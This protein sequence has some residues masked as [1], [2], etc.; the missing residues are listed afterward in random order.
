MSSDFWDKNLS[1]NFHNPFLDKY[2]E[3][4]KITKNNVWFKNK[5][6][7][8]R[9]RHKM[10]PIYEELKV[11]DDIRKKKKE[12]KKSLRD[13]IKKL[14]SSKL[15]KNKINIRIKT[16]KTKNEK[17]MKKI[18]TVTKACR[19]TIGFNKEQKLMILKWIKE[20][21]KIYNFCVDKYHSDEDYFTGGFTNAKIKIFVELYGKNPKPCPYDV[22]TDEVRIFCSNLKSCTTN[23]K[24]GNIKNYKLGYKRKSEVRSILIPKKAISKTGIFTTKMGK[25]SNFKINTDNIN[26]DSRL[27]YNFYNRRFTLMVPRFIK[28]TRPKKPG[29]VVSLDPGEKVFMSFFSNK[30]YGYIGKDVRKPILEIQKRIKQAQRVLNKNRNRKGKR[31]RKKYLVKRKIKKYYKKIKH[32]V[33]EMHNLTADFLCKRYERILIPEFKTQNILSENKF[34]KERKKAYESGNHDKVKK[35]QRT[36]RLSKRVKFV[37]NMLSHYRFRQHLQEKGKEYGCLVETVTE[38]FTSKTCTNCGKCS[39]KYKNRRKNC[40]DCGCKMDRD[41]N[42]ARNI[43]IKNFHKIGEVKVARPKNQ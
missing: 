19:Y 10:K 28:M 35:L 9:H 20:C 30:D 24:N 11:G 1:E 15:D 13:T 7:R 22:L 8:L 36:R 27:I 12:Y 6:F 43:L 23:K 14:K 2:K 41:V 33:K 3:S 31:I 38:E 4:K 34:K 16:L 17:N 18:N 21:D 5:I 25:I 42:G 32:L 26:G 29:K 39:D 37:L 40:V